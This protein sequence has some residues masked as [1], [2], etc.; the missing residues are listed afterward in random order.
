M[1]K[2]YSVALLLIAATF[3][4]VNAQLAFDIIKPIKQELPE[5]IIRPSDTKYN[6]DFCPRNF[7]VLEDN[8]IQFYES[9]ETSIVQYKHCHE[10]KIGVYAEHKD[11]EGRSCTFCKRKL[12]E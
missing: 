7:N 10:C 1:K 9:T 4:V 12:A 3:I 2:T 5:T 11:E 6:Y 8:S